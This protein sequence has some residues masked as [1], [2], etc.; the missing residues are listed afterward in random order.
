MVSQLRNDLGEFSREAVENSLNTLSVSERDVLKVIH[1]QKNIGDLYKAVKPLYNSEKFSSPIDTIKAI[2]P[3]F[4]SKG[5]V[6]VKDPKGKVDF[7][8]SSY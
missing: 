3:E 1:E 2:T 6:R 4:F 5:Y 7:S 8:P